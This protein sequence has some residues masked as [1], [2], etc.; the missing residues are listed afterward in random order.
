MNIEEIKRLSQEEP[1]E[2]WI[3]IEEGL[4]L[5]KRDEKL[6]LE[7][8]YL[9]QNISVRYLNKDGKAGL[10]YTTLLDSSEIKSTVL[11]AKI[12][13]DYGVPSLFPEKDKYPEISI[14]T[15]INLTSEV[16]KERLNELERDALSFDSSIFRV[17]K[18]KLSIGKIKY[19]LVRKELELIWE[20][21]FCDFFI[22]VIAKSKDKEASAYEWYSGVKFDYQILK[23]RVKL[24]CK[25]ATTLSKTKKGKNLKISVLFPP[26]VAVD[27]LNLLEFSFLGDEV[28]KGRSYLKDKLEKKIFSEKINLVDDGIN[29]DLIESRPFDDEGSAQNKKILVENGIIKN[30]LFDFY[31]KKEAEKRGFKEV[32]TGNSRRPDFSSFPKIS[33]TNFYLEK[34]TLNTHEL[35]N[36]EKEVFEVLEVLG[37]HTA[38]PISGDFSFGVSGIYYKNGEPADFFCEM[39]LSGNL[40][41]LF[42]N[43]VEIGADLSFYGSVGS[44][45]LLVE[46]IDL[47]G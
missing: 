18:I 9:D 32:K 35:I 24:A 38:N 6:F 43:V 44:P 41:E 39:A 5:E 7:E 27:L 47:G 22:S 19:I 15:R 21:P 40:F 30:F 33:S 12:L 31:W 23:E 1:V 34:G 20:S 36:L 29:P 14:F 17:E 42:K 16:L 46:K 25:K 2:F 45:S 28:L 37:A 26:F 4:E 10:S 8:N 3:E 11:K 13:S